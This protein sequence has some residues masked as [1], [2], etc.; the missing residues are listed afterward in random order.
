MILFLDTVSPLPVFS[1]IEENKV[2]KSI[3]I[4]SKNSKKI[5]KEIISLPLYP[6]I[7]KKQQNLVLQNIQRKI[8][9]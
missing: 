2:V 8:K 5:S 3:K 4:L 9:F 6:Q 1:V 7:R